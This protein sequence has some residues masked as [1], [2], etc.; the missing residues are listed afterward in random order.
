MEENSELNDI[1]SKGGVA[2]IPTDTIYGVVG[3][4]LN[5]K[6]VERIYKIKKRTPEKPFII[7]ISAYSDLKLFKVKINKYQKGFLEKYWP[8]PVS[9]ALACNEKSLEY[10]HRGT[11]FLAFRMPNDKELLNLLSKTG[12]L[13]APSANPE[14]LDPS[15]NIKMAKKYFSDEADYYLDEGEVERPP[16]TLVLLNED[17]YLVL[18]EGC[19]KIRY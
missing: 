4:A 18:R 17:K 5:R 15:S 11:K 8:G 7:L 10:L 3:K 1:L 12:P 2:V 19:I 13:V 9:V 14:G 6:T 16:S